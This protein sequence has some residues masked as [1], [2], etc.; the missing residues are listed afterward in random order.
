MGKQDKNRQEADESMG[1]IWE[2]VMASRSLQK[3][4]LHHVS[5]RIGWRLQCERRES[6]QYLTP[7]YRHQ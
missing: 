6:N 5:H 3:W 2:W 1:T 4:F 7:L